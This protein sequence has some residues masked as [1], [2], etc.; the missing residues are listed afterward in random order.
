MNTLSQFSASDTPLAPSRESSGSSR[1]NDTSTASLYAIL[2][3]S[4]LMRMAGDVLN[5][6]DTSSSAILG[7][8]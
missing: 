6:P 2:L 4:P 7:Y 8:N 5:R 3:H 1:S